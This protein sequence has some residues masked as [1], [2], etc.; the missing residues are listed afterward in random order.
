[1]A[2][3]SFDDGVPKRSPGG[4]DEPRNEGEG[5]GLR[6]LDEL[7]HGLCPGERAALEVDHIAGQQMRARMTWPAS[8]IDS[9]PVA[10]S[11]ASR[12]ITRGRP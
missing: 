3:H 6:S 2:A 8:A 11:F 10:E 9:S 1:M 12:E 7:V 4:G 5:S